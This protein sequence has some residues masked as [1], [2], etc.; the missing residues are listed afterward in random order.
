[1]LAIG[2]VPHSAVF[3][4]VAAVVHHGGAG[5]TAAA[6]RAGAPQVILPHL[7]DQY[8]WARRVEQLGLP[9]A[10]LAAKSAERDQVQ[11]QFDGF[12]ANL[13]DLLGRTE[14]ALAT[15]AVP[16]TPVSLTK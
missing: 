3:P 1:M 8:Y 7:L 6:A 13:K 15:G 11:A 10:K 9:A 2:S 4:R 14:S 12:R 5:T 16:G